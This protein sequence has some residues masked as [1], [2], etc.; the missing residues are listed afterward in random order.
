MQPPPLHLARALLPPVP[1]TG[2]SRSHP[3]CISARRP[4]PL[5]ESERTG[6]DAP[7]AQVLAHTR[8]NEVKLKRQWATLGV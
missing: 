6:G 3:M 5:G 1:P 4:D 7:A 8:V 2:S